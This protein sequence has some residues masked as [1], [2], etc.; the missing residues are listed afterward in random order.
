MNIDITKEE[1]RELL[2][3]LFIAEWVLHAFDAGKKVRTK[4]HDAIIQKLYSHAAAQ[5]MNNLIALDKDNGVFSPSGEL[6]NTTPAWEVIDNF[7]N[8]TFWDEL[9]HRLSER[10]VARQVGG[11]E[12]MD[13]LSTPEFI[14]METPV[15]ERYETEFDKQ[16][17]ERLEIVESFAAVPSFPPATHD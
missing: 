17:L 15:L 4:R 9:I 10:D 2:D 11:Y 13:A 14:T 7:T 5:G 1:Y 16:G 12:R 3:V 6:E 8:E